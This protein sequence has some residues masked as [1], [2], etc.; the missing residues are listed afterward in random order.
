MATAGSFPQDK[1]K[2]CDQMSKITYPSNLSFPSSSPSPFWKPSALSSSRGPTKVASLLL[3]ALLSVLIDW[4]LCGQMV[5]NLQ[6]L[7]INLHR[8]K[9]VPLV[10]GT[11]KRSRSKLQTKQKT[12]NT[13]QSTCTYLSSVGFSATLRTKVSNSLSAAPPSPPVRYRIIV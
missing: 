2:Q 4:Y 11:E 9:R 3:N 5:K 1:A 12:S 13:K 6:L 8:F 7:A 10:V